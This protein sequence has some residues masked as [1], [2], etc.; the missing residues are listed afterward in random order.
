MTGAAASSSP[1]FSTAYDGF[2][3]FVQLAGLVARTQL[4]LSE[5]D[6]RI[7]QSHVE[8]PLRTDPVGGEGHGHA[9]CCRGGRHQALDTTDGVRVLEDDGSWALVLP[10]PSEPVTHVWSEAGTDLAAGRCSSA[11]S[12][13]VS[14][15]R[16]EQTDR[17][18]PPSQGACRAATMSG[19]PAP[20][21]RGRQTHQPDRRVDSMLLLSDLVEDSLDEGYAAAAA[22]RAAREPPDGAGT[23]GCCCRAAR[24]GAAAR[25]RLRADP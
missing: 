10:D 19:L 1:Q 23:T 20:H 11:G 24:R 3:A 2:A 15:G 5:I 16:A 14:R 18:P 21:R 4:Q 17:T 6:T 8:P 9:G 22:R 7:P 25:D 13:C 12:W